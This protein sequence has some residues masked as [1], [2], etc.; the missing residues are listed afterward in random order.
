MF[1][2]YISF[3]GGAREVG[4]SAILVKGEKTIL[5]D[6][7]VKLDGKTQYPVPMH[8]RPDAYVLSHAHL[9]HSGFAP[10]LYSN[11][12]IPSYGTPPTIDLSRLL[13]EDAI[14]INK[15]K[16][17]KQPFS[18]GALKRFERAYTKCNYDTE[19][20]IGPYSLSLYDAG[21]ITGSAITLIEN[22]KTGKRLV[23]TGD[24]KI[25][26]Q[27]LQK[28]A[29]IVKADILITEST[30]ADRE[31]PDRNALIKSFIQEIKEIIDNGGT[32]LVPV[33]AV[34]RAQEILAM[35]YKNNL[36][37]Y[38]VIDGMAQKAT[39][40]IMNYPDF[41]SNRNL[42]LEAMRNA[43]WIGRERSRTSI[44]APAIVV[45][46][47]GMLNG[48][49]ALDYILNLN[50]KSKIFLTGFQ[51]PDTN[52]RRL[53]EGKPIIINGRKQAIDTPVS[54]YD[55]SAHAGRKDLY[56]YVRKSDPEKVIC[57]HGDANVASNFAESL[58]L[59][60]YD[61]IAPKIGETIEVNF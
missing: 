23:Y 7:G 9:D 29:E 36:I 48:G 21:H 16:R 40:I 2:M 15:R 4:R 56:D 45:T 1:I 61:A 53:L 50:K 22:R 35:L 54:Y 38:A 51:L 26:P 37:D 17:Q 20:S 24:F 34:G 27:L 46:T 13:I 8:E 42:L 41:S 12:F 25:E 47:A 19:I 14:K 18:K 5:L 10:A 39:E 43:T 60:G 28:G 6:Y 59:E 49:P 44:G 11:N 3:F 32:A 58:K 30:Y 31:H 52:G 57:V 33:F 55:F